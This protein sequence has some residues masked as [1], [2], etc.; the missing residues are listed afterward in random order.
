MP[1]CCDAAR[2]RVTP[3]WTTRVRRAFA[4]VLPSAVLA[5]MP[6]C[7]ACLAAYAALWTGL[8]MSFT[9]A[10]YARRALIGV[11]IASLFFLAAKRVIAHAPRRRLTPPA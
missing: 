8:G 2:S 1:A 5:F 6:K 9:A 4:W 10:A 7:P 3:A 11:C